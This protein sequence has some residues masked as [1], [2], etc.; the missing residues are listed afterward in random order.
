L[1]FTIWLERIKSL[2][3]YAAARFIWQEVQ[4]QKNESQ[5]TRAQGIVE[6][7][8]LIALISLVAGLA[9]DA[10]GVSIPELYDGAVSAIRGD[11]TILITDT[12]CSQT[13][14]ATQ[15]WDAFKDKSWRG[16]VEYQ[17]VRYQVCPQCGGTLP[18]FAG[19]DA[20]ISLAGVNV[21]NV[22]NSWNGYG[23]VFHAKYEK[24]KMNG[25]MFEIERQNKNQ[26]VQIYF[27]KWVKGKQIRPPLAVLNMTSTFDWENPPSIQIQVEGNKFTALLDGRQV[28]QTSDGTYNEGGVGVFANP[29]TQMTFDDFT[30][31]VDT[32][33]EEQ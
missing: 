5:L 2:K 6:Y 23:V 11:E 9:L 13:M 26:P 14:R 17:D 32:C 1:W 19:G 29:G 28:L 21:K 22:R 24:K 8:L 12:D 7:I 10:A 30:V 31:Q 18:G 25:Y 4:M 3:W 33:G 20:V 27:S 16:G 15:G